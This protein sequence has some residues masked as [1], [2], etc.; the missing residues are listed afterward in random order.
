MLRQAAA[1]NLYA[2]LHEVDLEAFLAGP[3]R[4]W[5]VVLAGDVL[6][7]F[8]ALER[9][10][11]LTHAALRPG[12]LFVCSV[13]ELEPNVDARGWRLGRQGRYAHTQDYLRQA[14][15]G[16]GFHVRALRREAV[17]YEAGAPVPG[18][19]AV[20]ERVRHDG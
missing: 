6:I 13:E 19:L 17:R 1:K 16:A 12:G 14:A 20:L 18:L 2:A 8:G 3:E 9:V 10:L 15:A 4:D 7:Y 11:S 5:A